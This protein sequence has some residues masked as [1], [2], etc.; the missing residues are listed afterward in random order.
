MAVDLGQLKTEINTDPKTLGISF[1]PQESEANNRFIA[2]RL[3]EIGASSETIE[4]TEVSTLDMQSAVIGSEFASLNATQQRAWLAIVGLDSIPIKNTNLRG[5]VL[6]VW[7][8]GTT[9]R[10]NLGTLQTKSATRSEVL[11]GENVSV[12]THDVH[13]AR[14]Q[15]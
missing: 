2:G 11:F 9:T 6:A 10:N 13:L 5:Q 1:D 3:N 12:S 15:P 4:V 14:R 7:A 8:G